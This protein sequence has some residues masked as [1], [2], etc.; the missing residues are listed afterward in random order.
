LKDWIYKYFSEDDLVSIKHEIAKV[1]KKTSGE[2]A[3]SFRQK[4]GLVDKLYKP[5]ELAMK[6]FDRM[7]VWNTKHRTG[8]LIFI[9]FDEKYYDII[10]DEGIYKKI[11]DKTWNSME[12]KLLA[13][14]QSGNFTAGVLHLI[15]K[16]GKILKKEFPIGADDKNELPDEVNIS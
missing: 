12:K 9:L 4:R 15:D 14:F 7:K 6:E 3:L 11:P 1:E 8:I 16:M 13:E 5:H 10:A 2:I